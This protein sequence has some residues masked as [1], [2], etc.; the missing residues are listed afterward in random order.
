VRQG[1]GAG[2]RG[3][4]GNALDGDRRRLEL[5]E[6]KSFIQKYLAKR[7]FNIIGPSKWQGN[8]RYIH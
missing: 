6:F 7:R 1:V 2:A 8:N 3:A 4:D 5:V